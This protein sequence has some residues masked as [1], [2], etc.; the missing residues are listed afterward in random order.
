MTFD[1]PDKS[2]VSTYTEKLLINLCAA[3]V[4]WRHIAE[5]LKTAHEELTKAEYRTL[6]SAVEFSYSTAQKLIKVASCPRLK[7]FEKKLA[8]VDGWSTLHEITKLL[9][10]EFNKFKA[11]YLCVE[12][13]KAISR[14]MV[15]RFRLDQRKVGEKPFQVYATI[16][17]NLNEIDEDVLGLIDA[18][19]EL[20]IE[21]FGQDKIS[22]DR[23]NLVE[24]A[25]AHYAR[26]A[27]KWWD[28]MTEAEEKRKR[29]LIN[30]RLKSMPTGR[31][32]KEFEKRWGSL[33]EVRNME[34]N[35]VASLFGVEQRRPDGSYIRS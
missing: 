33:Q 13:P 11:E 3:N 17:I 20:A 28:D 25:E 23:N 27:K 2:T 15:R 30:S 9:P 14:S 16:R 18:I 21:K 32:R 31:K 7:K 12:K 29:D 10:D 34:P 26:A 1:D 6:L 19:F 24:R 8:H 5:T 4:S 22:V 35:E